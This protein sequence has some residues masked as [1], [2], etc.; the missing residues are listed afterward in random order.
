M[1]LSGSTPKPTHLK[2]LKSGSRRTY[3]SFPKSNNKKKK[4]R[5]NS[6]HKIAMKSKMVARGGGT[7]SITSDK[8]KQANI[9]VQKLILL[10]HIG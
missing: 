5:K 7:Q 1:L 9:I 2:T 6:C 4:Y 3:L 8:Y 10:T